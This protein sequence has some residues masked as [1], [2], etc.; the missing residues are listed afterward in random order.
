MRLLLTICL[1]VLL[2]GALTLAE[3]APGA[4]V[5]QSGNVDRAKAEIT[6]LVPADAEVFFDGDPTIQKGT[7]RL[8]TT[9]PLE[10]G[11][12]YH[13]DLL[14]RWKQGGKTVEQTRKV[15]VSGGARVR[16]DFSTP[17]SPATGAA[18]GKEPPAKAEKRVAV[19]K[20]VT[21]G[22]LLVRREGAEKPWHLVEDKEELFS[23]DLLVGGLGAALDSRNGGV[24][25]SLQSDLDGS[26]PFPIIESAVILH[27]GAN[28]DLDLTFDRGRVELRNLKEKG[29]ARVRV[30]LQGKT[31]EFILD[32]PGAGVA[33]EVYGRWP[34]GVRFSKDPSS[35]ASPSLACLAL[36]LKGE[37]V[38]K[39]ESSQVLLKAPPGPALLLS[40]GLSGTAPARHHLDQ[41]PAWA[42]G[43]DESERARKIKA[44]LAKFREQIRKQP[45]GEVLD[46]MLGSDDELVRRSAVRLMGALD[47]LPRLGQALSSTKH[48]DVWDNGVLVL[49]HWIGRGPGQDLKLYQR[50]IATGKYTPAQA[51]IVL[52]LLHSFGDDD[53]AQPETYE[54]LINYLENDNLAIRGLAAWHLSR[55]VPAGKKIGYNPL[56]AKEERERAVKEWRNLIPEGK[57]PPKAGAKDG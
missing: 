44:N 9:P 49:R 42:T 10:V 56:A 14:A 34:K 55:L 41:L 31:G 52:N 24:R 7:E 32:E 46:Q 39:L 47:E 18:T 15:E 57:M 1:A 48:P 35:N 23:G 37:T 3:Q 25:L 4:P 27:E 16:V 12:K 22:G 51:A 21:E 20:C 6:V 30:H 19:A 28:V 40:D 53:L 36:A 8:F 43:G 33:L 11:K 45:I 13:Y 50:M 29:Q 54:V 17:H 26:S 5:A 38:V 2:G